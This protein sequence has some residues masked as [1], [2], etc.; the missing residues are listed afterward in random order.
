MTRKT[1]I[2]NPAA[3]ALS[4]AFALASMSVR[5]S[6]SMEFYAVVTGVPNGKTIVVEYKTPNTVQTNTLFLSQIMAPTL[7]QPG[8]ATAQQTLARLVLGQKVFV[9]LSSTGTNI[10]SEVY[11]TRNS[12]VD[13][14]QKSVSAQMREKEKAG[15]ENLEPLLDDSSDSPH[16][17]APNAITNR[18]YSTVVVTNGLEETPNSGCD[19]RALLNT[20]P[21]HK[22]NFAKPNTEVPPLKKHMIALVFL[23]TITVM[24]VA[25]WSLSTKRRNQ[26]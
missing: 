14:S 25:S 7:G 21:A 19:S 9:S 12:R 13:R 17:I 22:D 2:H 20:S 15:W 8:G 23:L 16:D 4:L 18:S 11:F 6:T 24:G 5:G 26:K 1:K 3:I 10:H